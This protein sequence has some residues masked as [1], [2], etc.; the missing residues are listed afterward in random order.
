M[1]SEARQLACDT[2][3]RSHKLER[4]PVVLESLWEAVPATAFCFPKILASTVSAQSKENT[5]PLPS[6]CTHD[7]VPTSSSFGE[8][9]VV[10]LHC[11]CRRPIA[12]GQAAQTLPPLS[13]RLGAW[14]RHDYKETREGKPAQPR[15]QVSPNTQT[16]VEH[17][18][19][20][21]C[22]WFMSFP[23]PPEYIQVLFC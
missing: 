19:H 23:L 20:H 9:M 16:R 8:W 10:T 17:P 21:E 14:Y 12:C 6:R 5:R 15:L 2:G 11:V 22:V 3:K 18:R 1:R 7:A 13:R 4:Y